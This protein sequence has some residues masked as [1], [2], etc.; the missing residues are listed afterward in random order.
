M[1]A[2]ELASGANSTDCDSTTICNT[3]VVNN[4]DISSEIRTRYLELK[5]TS[6]EGLYDRLQSL[7]RAKLMN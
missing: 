3:D 1:T 4:D 7:P 5:A 6:R 2:S